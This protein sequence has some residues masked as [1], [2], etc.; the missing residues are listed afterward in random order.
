MMATVLIIE[1]NED[2]M[3]LI[4]FILKGE[5]YD[6]IQ[7]GTGEDGVDLALEHRPDVILLDIQLPGIDGYEVLKRIR[8]T[9]IGRSIPI[10]A[11][12]SYAM[13]GDRERLLAAGCNG[14]IDK[15]ISPDT[16][17]K[18]IQATVEGFR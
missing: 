17:V 11:M 4:S 18:Q 14:Y 7:A 10:I 12:T 5:G 6:L 15:P 2:N 16:V 9:D 3:E 1:E 8:G 13:A